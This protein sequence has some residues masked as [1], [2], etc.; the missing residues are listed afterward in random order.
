MNALLVCAILVSILLVLSLIKLL[1][2]AKPHALNAVV[3]VWKTGAIALTVT[4][5]K[6]DGLIGLLKALFLLNRS[7]IIFRNSKHGRHCRRRKQGA[8]VNSAFSDTKP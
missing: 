7:K 2:P 6:L 3:P 5:P 4:T 1:E 8:I